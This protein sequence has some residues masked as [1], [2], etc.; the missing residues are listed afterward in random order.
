MEITIPVTRLRTRIGSI[1]KDLRQNPDLVFKITHHK[2]VI[3][4]LKAPENRER[5]DL[6]LTVEQELM[7]FVDSFMKGGVSR[8]KGTYQ[9]LRK[10]CAT[11]VEQLPYKNLEEAMAAI[12]GSEGGAGRF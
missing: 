8:K 11:P 2:E 12:R 3:A 9:R 1:L 5:R 4:E 7:A 10:L 6:Q